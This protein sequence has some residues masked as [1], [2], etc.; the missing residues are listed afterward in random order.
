MVFLFIFSFSFSFSFINAG[1]VLIGNASNNLKTSYSYG[2]ILNGWIN[3]SLINMPV[4]TPLTFY[5]S[6]SSLKK[7]L[8]DN[9][10]VDFNCSINQ[11]A[12]DYSESDSGSISKSFTL[13]NGQSKVI[14]LKIRDIREIVSIDN[15]ILNF[16]SNAQESCR[17]QLSVDIL[18]DAYSD[19]NNNKV[20]LSSF[21]S[22][23]NYGC[24]GNPAGLTIMTL[25]S[26]YCENINISSA[27][28]LV[29]GANVSGNGQAEFRFVVEDESCVSST[30]SSG[31]ISCNLLNKSVSNISTLNVCLSQISGNAYS[32]YYEEDNTCGS[33]NG[34]DYD[35]SIFARPLKY[36][37]P[38]EIYFNDVHDTYG[39]SGYISNTYPDGC[40]N[41]CYIPIKIS[42]NV[43]NQ[44][45]NLS[46]LSMR[47]TS[48][49]Q[50][51]NESIY[52]LTEAAS[53][54]NMNYRLLDIGS[55]GLSA[56]NISGFF[57]VSLKIGTYDIFKKTIEVLS[58]PIIKSLYPLELP[59]AMQYTFNAVVSGNATSY[60]WDFGDNSSL[61]TTNVNFVKHKY[62]SIG[63]K[64]LTLSATNENGQINRS[65]SINVVSPE[66]YFNSTLESY[67]SRS[68]SLKAQINGFPE[69]V[70]DYINRLF[71]LT[72]MEAILTSLRIKYDN[73]AGDSQEYINLF[74]S[75]NSLNMPSNISST[76]SSS[77]PFI[78]NMAKIN[79]A[80]INAVEGTGNVSGD[81]LKDSIFGWVIKNLE[82]SADMK[83]YSSKYD[84]GYSPLLTYVKLDITPNIPL[85]KLYVIIGKKDV[86][87]SLGQV[88]DIGDSTAITL[89]DLSSDSKRTLELVIPAETD[90]TDIPIYFSPKIS[91]LSTEFTLGSCNNDNICDK[92]A[93]ENFNNCS[94]DC[95]PWGKVWLWLMI[96][97]IVAFIVY[98][99]LQEWYKRRYEDYLFKNKNDLYNLIH[100]MSNSEEQGLDK[101]TMLIKLRENGWDPEQNIYAYNKF[102][103]KR[104]GMWE[105]P[106]FKFLEN[107]E[108][109]KQ[110]ELR[111][112]NPS[113]NRELAPKPINFFNRKITLGKKEDGNLNIKRNTPMIDSQTNRQFMARPAQNRQITP[114]DVQ[115]TV[116]GNASRITNGQITRQL[117]SSSSVVQ[118]TEA[119]PKQIE[120]KPVVENKTEDREIKP[121]DK[122]KNQNT[123]TGNK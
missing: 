43:D 14:G 80:D 56:P 84:D 83:L 96:L 4:N 39:I 47:Y 86:Q 61:I 71:N 6:N 62:T 111:N 55:L 104:T 13:N 21:C 94:K 54:V 44:L 46:S 18:N 35:F 68:N 116:F 77:G 9:P 98:I 45:I 59:A 75:L 119:K 72:D 24:Y 40:S 27:G 105:I 76:H 114:R 67:K 110:V 103:G 97:V 109:D 101:T 79:L 52:S 100:F 122:N 5:N 113:I 120:Q 107:R 48:G 26:A 99:L 7:L 11:C 81:K 92:E 118:S 123:N 57:N 28:G 63:P 53:F 29:V 82:V 34:V 12:S 25:N 65:F 87:A 121:E 91:V 17:N 41:G 58:L 19:L 95:K 32:I 16:S 60:I 106:L 33:V 22:D 90:L 64:I 70:K 30:S 8:E 49:V 108:V 74:E 51:V 78:M 85:E 112:Q 88:K 10:S 66:G 15:F 50:K 115:K 89:A 102:K 73:A 93:G 42:S 117:N 38:G 31:K 3:I 23:E 37:S 36:D 1:S 2:E 20:K 69:F